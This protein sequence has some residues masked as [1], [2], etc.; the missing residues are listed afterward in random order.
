MN[1]SGSRFRLDL[2]LLCVEM[3]FVQIIW[4]NAIALQEHFGTFELRMNVRVR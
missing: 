3:S 4:V 2:N 1:P